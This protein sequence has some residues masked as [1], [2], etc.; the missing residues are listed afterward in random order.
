M[1]RKVLLWSFIITSLICAYLLFST[2]AINNR[3]GCE[4][5]HIAARTM[6][7]YE[8]KGQEYKLFNPSL[9]KT[10]EGYV[11]CLR[12]CNNTLKNMF[13]YLS[14]KKDYQSHICI[15]KLTPKFQIDKMTFLN[16]KGPPLED[17]R[18]HYHD[19][20][21]YIS[22]T[23]FIGKKNI[24]PALYILD[25]A[26][27]VLHRLDYNRDDYFGSN[28]KKQFIQKNWCPFTRENELLLHTDTF[29][30][31]K[32]FRIGD[33][34]SMMPMVSFDSR[35]F[36]KPFPKQPHIRCSTSWKSFTDTTYICGLHTKQFCS[37]L[38]T[39]RT[40][41]VEIDKKTLKPIRSTDVFC[42]DN[43]NHVRIQF[44]SGLETD[45]MFVYLTFG[46]GDY[47]TKVIRMTKKYVSRLLDFKVA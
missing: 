12:Y 40:I 37:I 42:V 20:K 15:A 28:E 10:P 26:F 8:F 38:P 45:D 44:L 16:I 34:G 13:F 25:D 19:G 1:K 9:T 32:V 21:H 6:L 31:W 30:T 27:N 46:I 24:F 43:K 14:G 29:P 18:I 17:P 2:N 11:M 47:K 5:T 39:I 41:L 22:V 33:G 35:E 23:E 36:F 3:F 7:D 4:F